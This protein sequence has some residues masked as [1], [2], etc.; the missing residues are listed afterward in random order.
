MTQENGALEQENMQLTKKLAAAGALTDSE[1]LRD[2]ISSNERLL[3]EKQKVVARQR[4][5]Q[6]AN[7]SAMHSKPAIRGGMWDELIQHQNLMTDF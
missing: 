2:T 4:R 7:P 1:V 5:I 3:A 6:L